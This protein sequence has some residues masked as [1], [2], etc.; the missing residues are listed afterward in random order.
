MLCVVVVFYRDLRFNTFEPF[1]LTEQTW[2]H[3]HTDFSTH[4]QIW[5]HVHELEYVHVN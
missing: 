2:T 1:I 3:R 5:L 4:T